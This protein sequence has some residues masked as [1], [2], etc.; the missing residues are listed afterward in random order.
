MKGFTTRTKA[1]MT[2]TH[3]L[4]QIWNTKKKKIRAG[5]G[6]M[7]GRKYRKKTGILFVIAKDEG[8]SKAVSN[9]PGCHVCRVENLGVEQL[10]PGASPGR[11]T[12]WSKGAIDFLNKNFK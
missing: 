5:K 3:L 10:A 6:K 11:L 8:I 7:R 9:L 4:A 2:D 1:L 12:I